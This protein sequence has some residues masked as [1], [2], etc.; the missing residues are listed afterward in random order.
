M[1]IA[2][3]CSNPVNGGTARMFYELLVSMRTIVGE[4]YQIEA[5]IDANNPVEIYKRIPDLKRL[6]VYSEQEVLRSLTDAKGF[7]R[8]VDFV[9][10]RIRYLPYKK[11]NIVVM[12]RYLT[13]NNID[14]VIVHNGGY[15][16]D[17][18]CNQMIT[19]AYKC[20]KHCKA[21]ICVWHNDMEK[22][23]FD[24]L[25]FFKYDRKMSREATEIV[26]VSNYTRDRI[27][28]SSFLTRD[29]KVIYNGIRVTKQMTRDEAQKT[30]NV[31]SKSKNILMIG[32]FLNNKGQY[33]FLKA[34]YTLH[35]EDQ[36]YRFAIIGNIY[37][38]EYYNECMH[39]IHELQMEAFV[40][41]YHGLH[42]ASEYIE[43]FDILAVPSMYDESF[44]LISVE[45]MAN[46]V[47]VVAF[48]CGGIPEVVEEGKTGFLVPV[49]DDEKLAERIA[50]L[51]QKPDIRKNMGHNAFAI[52]KQKFSPEAMA[53]QYLYLLESENSR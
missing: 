39:L 9:L 43:L 8:I 16:G 18:L 2:M 51:E 34:A 35:N 37:E 11:K 19:A 1:K 30:V 14:G 7:R 38:Q 24:R 33:Q 23:L 47:P 28:R 48:A 40:Q 6:A 4:K 3:F 44:G 41:I 36:R 15:I 21:R 20:S 45:A 27:L 10:R 29:I 31:D 12:K 46:S 50:W 22:S 25:R 53:S 42:N 52:Y 26:T 32:N 5:C 13:E 17:D 49:G